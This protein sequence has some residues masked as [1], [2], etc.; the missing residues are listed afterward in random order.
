V[1]EQLVSATIFSR[2]VVGTA[3]AAGA[4]ASD[5]L[6][7]LGLEER[8]LNDPEGWFPATVVEGFLELLGERIDH[9]A[10]GLWVGEKVCADAGD[11]L[12]YAMRTAHTLGEAYHTAARYYG[13]VGTG[14]E[15]YYREHAEHGMFTHG[16]IPKLAQD[17]RHRDELV[18]STILTL[19]RLITGE[20]WTPSR[21]AFQ[22]EAP[23]DIEPHRRL[24]GCPVGFGEAACEIAIAQADT[25]RASLMADNALHDILQRYAKSLVREDPD[26][27]Q[28]LRALRVAIM[29]ALPAGDLSV[30]SMARATN[31]STRTL[32]RRLK[33]YGTSYAEFLRQTRQY[34]AESCLLG[35]AVSIDE[36]AF[37]LGYS[38]TPAFS[39]AFKRWTGETP[40]AF[41]QRARG[42]TG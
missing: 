19:G 1:S 10:P 30:D 33:E 14:V 8:D 42:A 17:R 27:P 13:L 35:A 29:H 6:A 15:V 41:R 21:V 3:R 22:H 37:L 5:L 40:G 34:L 24:F 4:S 9:S 25:R 36:V 31:T 11:L 26:H 12:G 16:V 2:T 18:L 20:A 38:A 7:R 39:R 23:D 32:Q 28:L